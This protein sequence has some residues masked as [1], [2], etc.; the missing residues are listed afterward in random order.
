MANASAETLQ[1]LPT[2]SPASTTAPSQRAAQSIASPVE[3]H[4][5]RDADDAPD[6]GYWTAYDHFMVER[7]ARAMRR[8][9]VWALVAKGLSALRP[10]RRLSA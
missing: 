3:T 10:R 1:L 6:Q 4:P 9:Y 8:A 2:A 5:S 7:E